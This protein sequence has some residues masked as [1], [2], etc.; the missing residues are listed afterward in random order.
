M[1]AWF[2][3]AGLEMGVDAQGFFIRKRMGDHP[4]DLFR[5]RRFEQRLLDPEP[6]DTL[7]QGATEFVAVDTGAR[8]V[9]PSVV[10]GKR[11]PWPDGRMANDRGQVRSEYPRAM[12]VEQRPILVSEFNYILEPLTEIFEA[13][14]R[15][16]NPVQWS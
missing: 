13:S 7:Y 11:I 16:G 1:R 8:F 15:V 12:H 5:S 3:S 9:C 4:G 6:L 10:S 2:G 14:I